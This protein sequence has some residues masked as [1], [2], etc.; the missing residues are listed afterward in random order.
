MPDKKDFSYSFPCDGPG[1]GGTCDISVWDAFYSLA[2]MAILAHS[3]LMVIPNYFMQSMVILKGLYEEI[4]R[5]VQ[6]LRNLYGVSSGFPESLSW[7]SEGGLL[8]NIVPGHSSLDIECLLSVMITEDGE[9]NLDIFRLWLPDKL[10]RKIVGIPPPHP[11]VES[12]QTIKVSYSWER[13]YVSSNKGKANDS[14]GKMQSS[15]LTDCWV[16]LSINGSV[17]KEAGFAAE[18]SFERSNS[19]LVRSIHQTLSWFKQWSI[20]HISREENSEADHL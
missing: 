15:F 13:Q 2:G 7:D 18:R 6:V 11:I 3:I 8:V 17:L 4:E 1:Q 20:R 14:R 16:I 19:A 5:M 9:W 12:C 10:I